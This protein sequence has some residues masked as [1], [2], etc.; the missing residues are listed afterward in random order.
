VLNVFGRRVNTRLCA[1][2]S[3]R[4]FRRADRFEGVATPP[5]EG[6]AGAGPVLSDALAFLVAKGGAADG[7]ALTLDDLCGR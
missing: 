3:C 7:N 2:I 6:A 4:R 5:L 1:P